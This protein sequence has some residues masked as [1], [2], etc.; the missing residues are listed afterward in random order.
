MN[1]EETI[2]N[3]ISGMLASSEVSDWI[4]SYRKAKKVPGEQP[5]MYTAVVAAELFV[6]NGLF[7]ADACIEEAKKVEKA[8]N[9]LRRNSGFHEI[10][11]IC[12]NFE[13]TVADLESIVDAYKSRAEFRKLLPRKDNTIY[14]AIGLAFSQAGQDNKQLPLPTIGQAAKFAKIVE[15]EAGKVGIDT[16]SPSTDHTSITRQMRTGM[17]RGL[18]LARKP[19]QKMTIAD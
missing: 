18:S 2:S 8:I 13:Q 16:D 9:V 11:E 7:S 5:A 17:D 4:S 15:S 12:V 3:F 10:H 6:G 1:Q 19:E 14:Y